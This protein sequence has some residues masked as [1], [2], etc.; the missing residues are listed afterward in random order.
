MRCIET[1][2]RRVLHVFD[3]GFATEPWLHLCVMRHPWYL[4]TTEE[5]RT[6]QQA[7]KVVFAYARRWDIEGTWRFSKSELGNSG[8]C[9]PGSWIT[10]VIDEAPTRAP[11]ICR[12]IGCAWPSVGSGNAP[13][14]LA[15]RR[16]A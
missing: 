3:R 7:W 11:P 16:L 15:M 14:L 2:G 10:S 13:Q 5:V 4:L 8:P 1:F 9:A 12:S 6:E